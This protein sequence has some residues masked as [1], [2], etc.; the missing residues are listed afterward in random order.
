M[1]PGGWF[2]GAGLGWIA[3]TGINST[4]FASSGMPGFPDDRYVANQGDDAL[5]FSLLAGYQW[6]RPTLWFPAYNLSLGYTQ[7]TPSVKGV[8]YQNSL[9]DAMNFEYKYNVLQ[10]LLMA[11]LKL[12]LYQWNHFMPYAS[13]G[14]G[15]A[16]NKTQYYADW[17]IPGATVQQRRYGF[18]SSTTTEFA[19]SIG[20]GLDYWIRDYAQ[21]SFG[22]QFTSSQNVKTGYGQG[23]LSANQLTSKMG[24]NYLGIQAIYFVD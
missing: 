14:A 9:A 16:I 12:D 21:L 15:V 19:G 1:P 11:T 8:I 5:S 17:P 7:N 4:N 2:V 6:Q 24:T 23:S 20:A 10:R 18:T 13:V 22:Y 3:P